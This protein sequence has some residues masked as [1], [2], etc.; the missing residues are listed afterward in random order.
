MKTNNTTYLEW[1]AE[2]HVNYERSQRW[3][4][5]GGGF[6]AFMVVYGIFSGAWSTALV[7]AFI[8]ALYYLVRNQSHVKH[9]I[10]IAEVGVIFDE[11]M[12]VWAELGEF[13]ILTGPDYHELHISPKKKSRAEIIIQ[14]GTIDPYELRDVLSQFLPQVADRRERLLDAIIR[15]CK[16]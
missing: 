12:F 13:W 1:Q 11:R 15:F 4:L 7:F 9:S 6:C 5:F 2:R 16:I 3:Y 10:K 8:P 14:T